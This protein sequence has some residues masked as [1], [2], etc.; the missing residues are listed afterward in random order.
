LEK[1]IESKRTY[2]KM[3]YNFIKKSLNIE[4]NHDKIAFPGLIIGRINPEKI[5][6]RLYLL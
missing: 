6:L 1:S 4:P 3:K 5:K 2:E